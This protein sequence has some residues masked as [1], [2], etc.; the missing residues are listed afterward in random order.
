LYEKMIQ[1]TR[2]SSR[3]TESKRSA[4]GTQ[5]ARAKIE[6]QLMKTRVWSNENWNLID[7]DD[8]PYFAECVIKTAEYDLQMELELA[9]DIMMG[10]I[11]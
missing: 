8:L 3:T 5:L 2:N 4:L 9:K 1:Q 10:V 11:V 7:A 6:S